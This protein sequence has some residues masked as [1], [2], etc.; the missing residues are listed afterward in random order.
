[1]SNE[2][3]TAALQWQDEPEEAFRKWA[4]SALC[5]PGVSSTNRADVIA[6]ILEAF[7]LPSS[8]QWAALH[9][10]WTMCDAVTPEQVDRIFSCFTFDTLGTAHLAAEERAFFDG[11]PEVV[12]VFRGASPDRKRGYAWTTDEAVAERFARGHRGIAV[13]EG[14]IYRGTIE[15][16]RIWTVFTERGEAEILSAPVNFRRVRIHRRFA[17]G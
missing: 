11:L 15:K 12:E 17:E 10:G 6:D 14:T 5:M 2:A 13:P 3:V 8:H 1:V 9:E 7:A 4:F 16:A